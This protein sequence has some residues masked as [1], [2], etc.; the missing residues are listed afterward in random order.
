MR[1]LS[2]EA[3]LGDCRVPEGAAA[4]PVVQRAPLGREL[5]ATRTRPPRVRWVIWHR[6]RR[7]PQ[8]RPP[9]P[10]APPRPISVRMT[11]LLATRASRWARHGHMGPMGPVCSGLVPRGRPTCL[12]VHPGGR[13]GGTRPAV[14]FC[15]PRNQKPA[16]ISPITPPHLG[17]EGPGRSGAWHR[18]CSTHVVSGDGGGV[19]VGAADDDADG[20]AGRRRV[21]A[22]PQ[23]RHRRCAAWLYDELVL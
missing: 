18:T 10:K 6:H 21:A 2:S 23:R 16:S 14:D 11:H 20:L 3:P 1:D 12:A 19:A 7:L 17:F 13:S 5:D 4:T 15:S 9:G 22:R 8:P